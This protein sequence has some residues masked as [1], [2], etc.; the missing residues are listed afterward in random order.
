MIASNATNLK[1]KYMFL[2][3]LLILFIYCLSNVL[4]EYMNPNMILNWYYNWLLKIGKV[5]NDELGNVISAKW[6]IYPI[7]FCKICTN[8]WLTFT[9]CLLAYLFG[10]IEAFYILPIL[11]F[12]NYLTIKF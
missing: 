2:S 3:V 11:V 9:I 7:G 10:Y 12:S 1:A 8:V 6:F 4:D 5:T